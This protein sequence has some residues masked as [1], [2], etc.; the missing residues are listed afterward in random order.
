MVQRRCKSSRICGVLRGHGRIDRSV[1]LLFLAG[2]R[3]WSLFVGLWAPTIWYG[4]LRQ[5]TSA[6]AT[7]D[8]RLRCRACRCVVTVVGHDAGNALLRKGAPRPDG[9]RNGGSRSAGAGGDER[10]RP[11]VAVETVLLDRGAGARGRGSPGAGGE[12]H[13]VVEAVLGQVNHATANEVVRHVTA[14]ASP[15]DGWSAASCGSY[16][17]SRSGDAGFGIVERIRVAAHEPE[18]GPTPT[19][20]PAVMMPARLYQPL[21]RIGLLEFTR[22]P[23]GA[24]CHHR[25]RPTPP[26]ARNQSDR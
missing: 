26:G 21:K 12:R 3:Q 7:P 17:A 25:R 14:V 20:T 1:A 10:H 24:S 4:P 16:R 15:T 13:R 8:R 6:L 2:K 22:S 23:P 18:G 11:L 5:D 19:N 9:T